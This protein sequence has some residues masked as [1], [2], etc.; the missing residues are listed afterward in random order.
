MKLIVNNKSYNSMKEYMKEIYFNELKP[1]IEMIDPELIN[2]I[3]IRAY[4][5]HR[6]ERE[7]VRPANYS[8]GVRNKKS[9]KDI[10]QLEKELLEG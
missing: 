8:V 2:Y 5:N 9:Y 6:L 3:N 4:I 1:F 7:G 10:T